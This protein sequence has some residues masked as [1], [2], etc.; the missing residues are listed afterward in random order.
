MTDP[1]QRVEQAL[2]GGSSLC[3]LKTDN[4]CE[5]STRNEARC[6]PL[7][8]FVCR[9]KQVAAPTPDRAYE[10][11]PLPTVPRLTVS[12]TTKGLNHKH[13]AAGHPCPG[14]P[15]SFAAQHCHLAFGCAESNPYSRPL[16][17]CEERGERVG[18]EAHRCGVFV[19]RT[20]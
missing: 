16:P 2:P 6:A 9:G 12:W 15:T 19:G 20:C 4:N 11:D 5:G 14:T 13:R 1:R 3:V 18:N 8:D 17:V 10:A 7:T